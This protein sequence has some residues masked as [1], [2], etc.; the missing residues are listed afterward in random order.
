MAAFKEL[1]VRSTSS[2]V[3]LIHS[4]SII[5]DS[6]DD[7]MAADLLHS[8]YYAWAHHEEECFRFTLS[9]NLKVKVRQKFKLTRVDEK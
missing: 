3:R 2:I 7:D 6:V 5:I 9:P 4:E 8:Q 1:D